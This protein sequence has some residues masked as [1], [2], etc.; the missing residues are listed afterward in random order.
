[1]VGDMDEKGN[2]LTSNPDTEGRKH[3][4]WL[5]MMYPRL[6][7]ARKFLRKDGFIFVSIDDREIHNLRMLMNLVF[8]EENFI[9]SFIAS[10]G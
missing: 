5:S 2:L 9:G 8:G 3:S 1:M 10:K 4:K 6:L 7:L